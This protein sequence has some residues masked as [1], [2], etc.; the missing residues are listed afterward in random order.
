MAVWKLMEKLLV[1]P[2]RTW[3]SM[4]GR[5]GDNT[6]TDTNA[7]SVSSGGR[8]PYTV[9]E[10]LKIVKFIVET[11]RYD[12]TGGNSLWKTMEERKVVPNRSWSSL[13]ERF[14]KVIMGNIDQFEMAED[15]RAA[16]KNIGGKKAAKQKRMKK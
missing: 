7:S 8:N 14:R 5:W 1:V 11:K 13:K 12:E 16:F 9:N 6:T 10:D 3:Q 4:K 15:I 2:G